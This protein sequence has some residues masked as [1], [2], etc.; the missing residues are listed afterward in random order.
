MKTRVFNGLLTLALFATGC[1]FNREAVITEP[2]GPPLQTS[3]VPSSNGNLVVYSGF[4]VTEVTGF[5]YEYAKPHTPYVIYTPDGKW[6]KR[7]RNYAGGMLDDP[8]TVSLPAGN[9]KVSAKANGYA[10]VTLPVVVAVGK[11]TV[12][13]LDSSGF[14]LARQNPK[15]NLVRL[16][17]GQIIGWLANGSS[18]SNDKP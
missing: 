18:D 16:P 3:H 15:A 10:R 14:N 2:V 9:Y 4:E 17:D 5:A 13:H 1:A 7:V 12:V 8:E 6:V 11:T